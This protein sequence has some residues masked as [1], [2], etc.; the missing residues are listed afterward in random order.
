MI[1]QSL[2]KKDQKI[3]V[4]GLGYVGLPIALEFAKYF[5]VIGFD[6]NKERIELMQKG[7]D[8][9]KELDS[10]AF[11]GTDIV[12]TDQ[13]EVLKKAHFFIVAVPTDIDEH[14]VPDLTPLLKASESVGKALKK[15]DYVVFESTVYPGCTE[16]DCL[17]I[18]E[19]HSDL[20]LGPD[21]KI[22]YS[23]ERIVPGDKVRTLTKILKVVAGSDETALEEISKVYGHIIEAGI[24]KA[25]S[26]K[27]AEAAKV[28]E[29][30]QRDINISLMNELSIIFDKMDI[31]TKAVLEAA[32]TKWN[33][34][35]YHPGLVGGHCISVDPFYL[36]HKAKQ[37]GHD[38]QVIA[39][40]RRVNDYIPHF[41]AKRLVQML[42][43]N[44]KNPGSAKVLVLGITFKEN[45]SDI[46]NSKVVN[47][48][49]ELMDYS[50]NVHAVD[51]YA[52]PNE[53]AREY[54]ISLIDKPVGTYDAIVI[55]VA[56]N[57]YKEKDEAYFKSLSNG[58]PIIFDLKGILP[59]P[60]NI[61]MVDLKGQYLRIKEEV[62]TAIQ[63][64]L[65]STRF[66]KGPRVQ[67]FEDHLASFLGVKD[68]IS[69]ANGTDALQ[70]ALMALALKPGDEVI[71]PAFTYVAT[72]EVI[73]LLGLQPI[74]VDV[75]ANDFNSTADII[76]KAITSKT[77]AIVPVH[78]FGQ[79]SDMEA[80]MRVALKHNLFVIEDNAQAIGAT[81]TFK[82]GR[83]QKAGTISHIGTTSFFPS[84]NLGC[85]G[86]GGALFTNDKELAQRI[87][88]IANHGQS[89]RYYHSV[90]GV[91]S[92]L[93][94]IQAVILDIK[95]KYL[96]EYTAARQQVAS[97]YDQAFK[98]ISSLQIPY[99]HPNSTHVFHQYTLQTKGINRD[100]LQS[101]LK[102]KGIPS[103][104][105]YPIPLYKQDAFKP[106]INKMMDLPVTENLCQSVISLPIHTEMKEETQ[107]YIIHHLLQY[108]ATC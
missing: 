105:Y 85:Y 56:H 83:Q 69:C 65:A 11:D 7:I 45:I 93:D 32:G 90:V 6:I 38:P 51:P 75:D 52:S 77:K 25:P 57:V 22:G 62:D 54:G 59:A 101:Y 13:L 50:L 88:M 99:R 48:I 63:E 108:I 33:F 36:L 92:R 30:T 74:M 103:M 3:A 91:N 42:I 107:E 97:R 87:R 104:V 70:V 84:K 67:D 55:A 2:L 19:Q 9:S 76:E 68:V 60:Q 5:S 18:L 41:I 94:A 58:Q 100:E 21:F 20:Q 46:R 15:G 71:V 102:S 39:A 37:L 82:N 29:N 98:N 106:Y 31:D 78:L 61:H 17:P 43:E 72:A 53:V 80:I 73:A 28:I 12:F 79:C 23:P 66:I 89:K 49:K 95:L 64:V 96:H 86:D 35:K 81:Y 26:I 14:K 44:G 4:I 1:Y 40:G 8:P 24:H 16:E 10:S 47:L 34:H 27:V